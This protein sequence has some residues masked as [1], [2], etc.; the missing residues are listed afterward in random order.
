MPRRLEGDFDYIIVGAG[1]AGCI[2]A[3]RLSADPKK[4]VLLLEAGGKDNWIWFHIP[5]GYLFA[6]GNPR[7]D[8]MFKTEAEPGLNG[9]ALAYPRGKVIG[10]SSAINAMI[11]M[12]GQAEDYDHWRQLGLTGWSYSDVLPAFKRLEDH[13]LGE[14]EHHGVGGGW[15][16]EAPRLSWQILDAVG[17]AAEEMG[18]KRIPDFNTG[19][20]EGTSYFHVNQKRGRRWSSAR[21]FLKPVL[22]RSNLRLETDVLVDR[23][24]IESGRAA[25]VLFRQGN[26][27]VEARARG[28]VI[29]CAGSIGTTQ[30]LQRSGIGPSE[31]LSPLGIDIVLDVQGIG[32]NLQDHLQQRAI[33]KV[34]GVRT[35]NETYYNLV[36]RGLMGLDYAFRRRG[37]LTMA[38]SQLG[39]FTRSD[40][41]RSRANIQF[42]VQPL[43]L[44]KF[45]DPL[46]RFPAITVSA[47]NLQP[48]SRGTVR[49]K[50][51]LPD[52]KPSIAPNYLSTDDDR[53]VAAD[54]IRT[55][56]RLMK[57]KA[58]EKHHPEEFL[59]G[60]S[61]GDDDAS[62]AKAAGDIGT[63]IFHPVGTAKM[64]TANDPMAV[65]DERL[66]FYGLHGLRIADASVMPTI[67]SGNTNTPTAMIAEKAAAMILQDAR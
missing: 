60:P 21:G 55:T 16:I 11:S 59:P 37:P 9:R 14:S 51:S 3:N 66:R 4:R 58:L 18:I 25:G 33:Y 54:A 20:N 64:G 7:S 46:H 53:Q 8:W 13:F 24:V 29:L 31:W 22:N 10:G 26:E 15:R 12:R 39:I 5:V 28:E 62:L 49:I 44:D 45:G 35:L 19:D 47:C 23:L 17:D 43:S 32:H 50:S 38:P 2:M 42:H 48:S 67:T 61:V 36:R 40:A 30:V 65:V 52:D 27:T 63:T 41:T 1:T 6:I 56:R 57:Q 34:S